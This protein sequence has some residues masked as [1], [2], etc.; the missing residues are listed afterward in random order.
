MNL[1]KL[2]RVLVLL[3]F[4]AGAAGVAAPAGAGVLA[5]NCRT[6]E[7][8]SATLLVP[9]FEVDLANPLGRTTLVSINNAST[10]STLAR[11]VLWT[12]W[13]IPT[14]AFDL[15]LTGFDVQTLNLRDLFAGRLPQTGTAI[16]PVGALS[17]Q[18]PA[19][20][21]GCDATQA[22]GA[23]LNPIELAQLRA[24]HSGRP[25]GAATTEGA[26]CAGAGDPTTATGYLTVDSALR[27][28]PR[29]VGAT[30]NTP[31]DLEYFRGQEGGVAGDANVLWGDAFQ[32]DAKGK[33][34]LDLP[35]VHVPADPAF[36]APGDYTFYG[37]YREYDASDHRV[38]LSSLYYSRFAV[39][40]TTATELI[41]WRDTRQYRPR[42]YPCSALPSWAPL[43]EM[44]LLAFDEEEN[45]VQILDSNAFPLATQKVRVGDPA[46]PTAITRGWLL[47]DLWHRDGTHA[48]GWVGVVLTAEGRSVSYPAIRADDMCNFGI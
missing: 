25:V 45:G 43:G 18:G 23:P 8:P 9:Y 17:Q 19:E 12:N 4:S 27:C 16:S 33:L 37:R 47:L 31:V 30:V 41:V 38:P 20:L 34:T 36:F 42:A 15:Y 40:G 24:A 44:Q 10:R 5:G 46:I 26:L 7:Q 32:V 28:T 21:P 3:A 39:G 22:A 29:A 35:V 2:H 13:G 11:V 6:G 14:L 1:W 48:Q